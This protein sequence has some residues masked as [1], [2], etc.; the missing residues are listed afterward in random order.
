MSPPNDTDAD[1]EED[2]KKKKQKRDSSEKPQGEAAKRQKSDSG[3]VTSDIAADAPNLA[4]ATSDLSVSD[5]ADVL[6]AIADVPNA[7]GALLEKMGKNEVC[8]CMHDVADELP[9]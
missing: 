6:D 5:M 1:L 4:N 3:A 2:R 7:M 8:S 9:A